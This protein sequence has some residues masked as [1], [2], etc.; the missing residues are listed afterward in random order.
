MRFVVNFNVLSFNYV[1]NIPI[2]YPV[3]YEIL[4]C[5]DSL[6]SEMDGI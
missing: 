1:V 5:P 6:D 4:I 2:C 3:I